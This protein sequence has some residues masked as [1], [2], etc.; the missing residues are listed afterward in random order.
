VSAR[1]AHAAA[2]RPKPSFRDKRRRRRRQNAFRAMLT[3]GLEGPAPPAGAGPGRVR[4][5]P[6]R[7]QDRLRHPRCPGGRYAGACGLEARRA[8][9]MCS[10]GWRALV[11]ERP[12]PWVTEPSPGSRP[13]GPPPVPARCSA[14]SGPGK[15]RVR[16][17]GSGRSRTSS[18]HPGLT[19][20]RPFGPQERAASS[21]RFASCGSAPALRFISWPS[22]KPSRATL[23]PR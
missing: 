9:Q 16:T 5:R 7:P 14:P 15:I 11:F 19:S 21:N 13:E 10:P 6:G 22:R 23:P 4:R 12:E 8:G 3:Q 20:F 18:L 17:Q 2:A 1:Q